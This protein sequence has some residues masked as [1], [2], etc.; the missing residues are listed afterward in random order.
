ALREVLERGVGCDL[1]ITTGGISVGAF[2]YTR[3]VGA[4]LGAE[5]RFWKVRM[6]PG[7]PVGYGL[8]RGIP[9]IGLPGNPVST[10][11]TFELFVRPALRLMH[12]HEQLFRRPV[13]VVLEEPVTI[14]ADL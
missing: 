12:G 1:I 4:E 3:D 8:L 14:N 5:M 11:V 2:D 6:R 13:P 9:W 7:A 10:M